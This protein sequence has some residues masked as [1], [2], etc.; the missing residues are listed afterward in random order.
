MATALAG[1]GRFRPP[2]SASDETTLALRSNNTELA[3]LNA[4]LKQQLALRV[5]AEQRNASFNEE[6]RVQTHKFQVEI[7]ELLQANVER[8]AATQ[9]QLDALTHEVNALPEG[10]QVLRKALASAN[11]PSATDADTAGA[12][13]AGSEGTEATPEPPSGVPPK[14]GARPAPEHSN[15]LD[16]CR[17]PA[18]LPLVGSPS[19]HRHITTPPQRR[20]FTGLMCLLRSGRPADRALGQT[21]PETRGDPPEHDPT[22]RLRTSPSAGLVDT[23]VRLRTPPCPLPSDPNAVDPAPRGGFARLV[24]DAPY[25]SASGPKSDTSATTL[26]GEGAL[27]PEP[28]SW[29]AKNATTTCARRMRCSSLRSASDARTSSLCVIL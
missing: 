23:P 6:Q 13:G 11:L 7:R 3:K 4:D 19:E 1:A 29:R 17:E 8:T 14:V 12:L 26:Q 15:G 2:P 21:R 28:R 16:D 9:R 25:L 22:D 20:P 5:E 24:G 27:T 10:A 18:T